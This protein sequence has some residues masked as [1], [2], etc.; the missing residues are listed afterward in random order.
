[1]SLFFRAACRKIAKKRRTY[2]HGA[3]QQQQNNL[4]STE[5]RKESKNIHQISHDIFNIVSTSDSIQKVCILILHSFHSLFFYLIL[6]RTLIYCVAEGD[7]RISTDAE[8]STQ[9]KYLQITNDN[10]FLNILN[11][12]SFSELFTFFFWFGCRVY[13]GILRVFSMQMYIFSTKKNAIQIIYIRLR[14]MHFVHMMRHIAKL[15]AFT[16]HWVSVF[17]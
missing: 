6:L 1:M 13:S 9:E 12:H 17:L 8:Y 14:P 15:Y 2:T 10:L 7:T 5:D 11:A 3:I 4:K 16:F